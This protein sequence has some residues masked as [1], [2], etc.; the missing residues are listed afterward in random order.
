MFGERLAV[1]PATMLWFSV[2]VPPSL[3]I[4]PPPALV[5]VIAGEGAVRQRQRAAAVENRAAAA[6]AAGGVIAGEGAVRQ[7]QRAAVVENRAA[8]AA[9]GGVIAG[10]GAVRQRQRAARCKSRR[11]RSLKSARCRR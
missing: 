7:R 10:E 1:F 11:R 4:A 8:A 9:E 3:V 5:G 2:S 6:V